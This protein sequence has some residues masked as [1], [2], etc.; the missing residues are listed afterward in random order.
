MLGTTTVPA[1]EKNWISQQE[2]G[3]SGFSSYQ[4]QPHH[5]SRRPA[6]SFSTA[7][8]FT[9]VVCVCVCGRGAPSHQ[10][11]GVFTLSNFIFNF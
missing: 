6:I 1:R 2:R 11:N 4:T 7:T 3:N 10:L 9:N 5:K 8:H